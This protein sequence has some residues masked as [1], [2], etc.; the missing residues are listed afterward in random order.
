MDASS[1]RAWRLLA[2]V[3]T[4]RGRYRATGQPASASGARASRL[5]GRPSHCLWPSKQVPLN[6]PVVWHG[7]FVMS[8]QAQIKQC[9]TDYQTG[10]FI[11]HKAVYQQL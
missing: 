8:T 11:K 1:G 6:E 10:N 3:H 7:P 2:G 4:P 9:F 5:Q